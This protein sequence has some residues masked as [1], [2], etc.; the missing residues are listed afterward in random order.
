KVAALPVV[1]RKRRVAVVAAHEPVAMLR[2]RLRRLG[3]EQRREPD[4]RRVTGTLYLRRQPA[5]AARELLV[6][7]QPVADIG[8]IAVVDLD[9]FDRKFSP[10]SLEEA[11]VADDVVFRDGGVEVVPGAPARW[12]RAWHTC[13]HQPPQSIAVALE[14][15]R[16]PPAQ[17]NRN[18][19]GPQRLAGSDVDAVREAAR[20]DRLVRRIDEYLRDEVTRRHRPGQQRAS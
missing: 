13:I 18:A 14:L 1:D 17:I 19:L 5:H 6:H 12:R 10:M 7:G 20:I 2:E 16:W 11:Q 15:L 4:A 9:R 8:L 3:H